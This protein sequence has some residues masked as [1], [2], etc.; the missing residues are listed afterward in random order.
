VVGEQIDFT[1]L[2]RAKWNATPV[3]VSG[4]ERHKFLASGTWCDASIRTGPAGY[5]S[6]SLGFRLAAPFRRFPKANW[7]ALIGAIHQKGPAFVIGDGTEIEMPAD[8][9]L[10]CFANDLPSF[11]F[12]NSGHVQVVVERVS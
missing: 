3:W 6:S 11:Y 1:V 8:G 9:L 12:N 4:G 2:A 5:A 10:Y 7:F